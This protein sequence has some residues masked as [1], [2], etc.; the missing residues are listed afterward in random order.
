[1]TTAI[2][3]LTG[4]DNIAKQAA[5]STADISKEFYDLYGVD[6]AGCFSG[7]ENI[8]KWR[9]LDSGLSFFTPNSCAGDAK[10]YRELSRHEW[11]YMTEKWEYSAAQEFLPDAGC[12]LE[13]GCGHGHFLD[14]CAERGLE[15]VGLELSPPDSGAS[16]S[17]DVKIFDETV[18]VHA[19]RKSG[20]YDAVCSFQVLEHVPEPKNFLED[21]CKALKHGGRLIL[22]TPNAD[23]FLRH[24][25]SLLD[26]PPHHIT[27]WREQTF[28]YLENILPLR[29]ENILYEPL[30]DY[31]VDFFLRTY[32]K[33]YKQFLDPR[34]LWAKEPLASLSRRILHLG[35]RKLVRGQ[36]ILAVLTR[37]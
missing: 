24:A 19:A 14:Q 31:H 18:G 23:S 22:G 10:F 15:A 17:Q 3:P 33:R 32:R 9:C 28:R 16:K 27:G 35:A 11:Y 34:G 26:M 5:Y 30:A 20:S 6:V 8:F 37:I 12:V 4:R 2:S 21:C 36:S 13:I 1:M 25:R 7:L 29:I